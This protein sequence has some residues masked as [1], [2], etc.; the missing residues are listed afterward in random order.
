MTSN[1][2]VFL[3]TGFLGAGKTSFLQQ[4]LGNI[5]FCTGEPTLLLLCEEGEIDYAPERFANT[6]VTL[7]TLEDPAELTAERLE[8]LRRETQAS[9]VL[10]EYNGMWS[11]DALEK[12]LP[13]C[14]F[15]FREM[16][17][18]DARTFLSYNANLRQ[19][20]YDKLKFCDAAVF[21]Q[22]DERTDRALIHKIVR[23][24][25]RRADIAYQQLD[26][27]TEY[28]QIV[29]TDPFD[30]SA[31]IIEIRDEDYAVWSRDI[32]ESPDKYEG[33]TVRIKCRTVLRGTEPEGEIGV[34]R[35]VMVCCENDIQFVG[36]ICQNI[37]ERLPNNTW[38]IL[39]TAIHLDFHPAYGRVGPVLTCCS[40]EHC[41]APE[42]AV[43]TFY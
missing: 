30:M 10:I 38:I 25:S 8:T 40:L 5:N 43:A 35:Y 15:I 12:A 36:F 42:S 4:S 26:G 24:A 27:T 7:R 20:V 37:P 14:W 32:S 11:R 19:L 3:F 29:D 6:G 17:F 22:A 13:E 33:K 16:A 23:G 31:E 9:R 21:N 1:I 28:D 41:D 2:T 18:F 39:T 34:G